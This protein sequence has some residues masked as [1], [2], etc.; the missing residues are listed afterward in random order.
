M[1]RLVYA[2][3]RG[4]LT[5]A[6]LLSDETV[7]AEA[8]AA[9]LGAA[10]AEEQ[11]RPRALC[12]GCACGRARPP[13]QPQLR[14]ALW[15]AFRGEVLTA[16]AYKLGW[17][18]F[19]LLC[20]AFFVRRLLDYVTRRAADDSHTAEE[21]AEGFLVSFF[22]FVA[23]LLM[24]VCLQQMAAVSGRL[25]ARV[26]AAAAT[27]VYRKS[28]VEDRERSQ[29]GDGALD[30]LSLVSTDCAKLGEACTSLQY[31][32]SGCVEATAIICVLIGF[33]GEAALPGL[34]ALL[35]LVPLQFVIG[36]RISANR[37]NVVRAADARVSLMD[38][39]L[40]AIK[41]V[42]MYV[43]E[44]RFAARVALL[45]GE[46][47]R[48]ARVSGALKSVLV[49]S[50]FWLPPAI[51]LAIF[52]VHA[53]DEPLQAVLA[54]TTL[55]LF[56]TLRL[57]L[58]QL[59][60]GLRAAAEAGAALQ[61]LQQYLTLP[62][63]PARTLS[64]APGLALA[65][66]SYAYGAG[67][68]PL[69]HGITLA[70]EA[71]ALV[72]VAGG[73]GA[74][75]SNLV[76]ALLGRM[77]RV[78]GDERLPDVPAAYV[79]QTPWCAHGTVRENI[80]FGAPFDEARYRRVIFACALEQDL[81]ILEAGDLTEVGERGCALSGG[82]RQ[83][84]ALARAA[85]SRARLVLLDSPLS[86]VD[87]YTGQHIFRHCIQGLMLR[88]DARATVVLVT[89]QVE[90]FPAADI[91][92]VMDKGAA[93]YVGPYSPAVARAHFPSAVAEPDADEALAAALQLDL[94]AGAAAQH[95]GGSAAS[96]T[97]A[98]A[99]PL[100]P[101]GSATPV[102]TAR[103]PS[104]F[105][106]ALAA[107][108]DALLLPQSTEA[109]A[110]AA[111]AAGD[112]LNTRGRR[113]ERA[114][115]LRA[116]VLK[117]LDVEAQQKQMSHLG[118]VAVGGSRLDEGDTVP[119]THSVPMTPPPGLHSMPPLHPAAPTAAAT[120]ASSR[121]IGGNSSLARLRGHS[122]TTAGSSSTSSAAAGALAAAAAAAAAGPSSDLPLVLP[123]AGA[124]AKSRRPPPA[125]PR[126]V[127]GYCALLSAL[128]W[129][130]A[131]A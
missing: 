64:P 56:N 90:L 68:P 127:N 114:M 112:A 116:D 47:A 39:V 79:P 57:P 86:A 84:V 119:K 110:A 115:S 97:P 15:R 26:S 131:L 105:S 118:G 70:A 5:E 31:L 104:G 102:R 23:A 37:K 126:P 49:A 24:C 101:R 54:F 50:V 121:G 27:A 108:A 129:P 91:L 77:T 8:A 61:R 130:L 95:G 14:R 6:Q 60:K 66:A 125:E 36:Q 58:V 43:W 45:R 81:R 111:A 78:A 19:V 82:Q 40:R 10:W 65:G 76:A 71:G 52:G 92:I 120:R 74:G 67:T 80:L 11:A 48:L 122:A 124:D 128:W 113:S 98:P 17:G 59:P 1:S 41:L 72:M 3:A 94:G 29:A 28:L 103:A 2:A 106:D 22:F 69:L 21:A 62:E 32:W 35:L 46:E 93:V 13:V 33:V 16:A 85:Y 30:V 4:T 12:G 44:A 87:A 123:D 89:H 83:R 53:L 42:K 20:A 117:A 38:E 96:Q 18:F 88:G 99:T 9:A 63:R 109:T 75:K 73:V 100:L 25:G 7:A 55:S 34:G 51:A 107:D